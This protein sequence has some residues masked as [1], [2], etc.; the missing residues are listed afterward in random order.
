MTEP[1]AQIVTHDNAE[2]LKVTAT[3][4]AK[5]AT[6]V[7]VQVRILQGRSHWQCPDAPT[8]RRFA[9][10]AA[11]LAGRRLKPGVKRKGT[12]SRVVVWTYYYALEPT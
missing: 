3:V 8:L 10:S 2:C 1:F 12:D 6:A 9:E 11:E 4:W 5:D 7:Q